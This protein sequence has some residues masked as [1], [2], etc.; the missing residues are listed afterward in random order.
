MFIAAPIAFAAISKSPVVVWIMVLVSVLLPVEMSFR[1]IHQ[2]KKD[3]VPDEATAW[4]ESHVPSGTI[5][6]LSPS[7]HDPLPTPQRADALWQEEMNNDAAGKKFQA[8]LA[9]FHLGDIDPPRALSEENMIVE[10]VR[11]RMW[12][13]LGSRSWL[14][15]RRYDIHLY[16]GSTVFDASDPVA[17]LSRLGGVLIWRGAPLAGLYNPVMKWVNS[18]GAG[19]YIYCSD[20]VRSRL[21]P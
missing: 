5:V 18:A 19:T 3:Y 8:G 15:D 20:N 21:T 9:R 13:I 11:R 12:Y 4:V 7:L 10:R 14:P 6:L 1:N 16:Q 2:Q 17:E